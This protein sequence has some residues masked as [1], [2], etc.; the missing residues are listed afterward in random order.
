M[1]RFYLSHARRDAPVAD[2]FR[3]W[4]AETAVSHAIS[5]TRQSSDLDGTPSGEQQAVEA[6][7]NSDVAI[8]ICSRAWI[9]CRQCF[10]EYV[11]ARS[12]DTLIVAVLIEDVGD[13]LRIAEDVPRFKVGDDGRDLMKLV[14]VLRA[15]EQVEPKDFDWSPEE[16]PYPGLRPFRPDEAGVFFGRS[17]DIRRVMERVSAALAHRMP[18]LIAL[19]GPS[20][21]G[22]SS[23]LLAGVLPSIR[24]NRANVIVLPPMRPRLRPLDAFAISLATALGRQDRWHYWVDEL[25]AADADGLVAFLEARVAELRERYE[26]ANAEVLLPVDQFE[27]I[28][29]VSGAAQAQVFQAMLAVI[30]ARGLPMLAVA[31]VGAEDAG[32]LRNSNLATFGIDRV[33]IAPL[34]AERYAEIIRGPAERAGLK[35]EEGLVRAIEQ[36]AARAKGTGL[37]GMAYALRRIY[38]D[39]HR[40]G[41]LTEASYRS[42]VA[43]GAG[44]SPLEAAVAHGGEE[45]LE[46]AQAHIEERQS[47]QRALLDSLVTRNS[48]GQPIKRPAPLEAFPRE[49]LEIIDQ[50]IEAGLLTRIQIGDEHLIEFPSPAVVRLWPRLAQA[51]R[52]ESARPQIIASGCK[53]LACYDPP[54]K[55]RPDF[56]RRKRARVRGPV[57]AALCFGAAVVLVFPGPIS[58]PPSPPA[59]ANLTQETAN[60]PAAGSG[61]EV[62]HLQSPQIGTA[63]LT[64]T[65]FPKSAD[66]PAEP[67]PKAEAQPTPKAETQP[68]PP[69]RQQEQPVANPAPAT[70]WTTPTLLEPEQ[71]PARMVAMHAPEIAQRGGASSVGLETL[72]ALAKRPRTGKQRFQRLLIAVEALVHPEAWTLSSGQTLDLK[73][74]ILK[75]IYDLSEPASF[76]TQAGVVLS[77]ALSPDGQTVATAS[78]NGS[79]RL[80]DLRTR[81]ELRALAGHGKAVQAA[82]FSPDGSRVATTS[83]DG[84]ARIWQ[85]EGEAKPVVLRGHEGAVLHAAFHPTGSRIVTASADGTARIWNTRTGER[86]KTLTGHRVAVRSAAFSAD[87]KRIVTGAKDGT[88]RIW[89]AGTGASLVVL[90]GHRS[91]VTSAAFS[92]DGARVATASSDGTVRL[93]DAGSGSELAVL[94]GHGD[95]VSGAQFSPDGG[96]LVSASFD[97][98]V[99]IWDLAARQAL[100]AI[101]LGGREVRSAQFAPDGRSVLAATRDGTI[102]VWPVFLLPSDLVKG[103]L[104]AAGGCLDAQERR[105]LALLPDRPSW[106]KR[107]QAERTDALDLIH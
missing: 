20:G 28:Y 83:G 72:L 46:L 19:T 51:L 77:A 97:G 7:R 27:E 44:E 57:A 50:L 56:W 86:L 39:D 99:R 5:S 103:A 61:Q 41:V 34:P 21:C 18:R 40:S 12:S 26:T 1:A 37:S 17:A 55:T 11:A 10:A 93:W 48:R 71:A 54:R 92:P 89:N 22:L 59:Q 85:V 36:D 29:H 95:T 82:A 67:A 73:R 78:A 58:T 81:T 45:A 24:R 64:P 15:F 106:C 96:F 100:A 53:E 104:A 8:L 43:A 25:A 9:L 79:T 47:A 62:A 101:K 88:A 80:W 35:V 76:H 42:L 31:T 102:S 69:Q 98:T 70:L 105:A 2:T 38:R 52:T 6:V 3:A 63:G 75:E 94:R 30:M 23:L 90:K 74:A 66:A 49:M 68:T 16:P 91:D 84:T 87:G 14:G 60:P 32:T 33:D 107:H 4:L 13:K 65:A